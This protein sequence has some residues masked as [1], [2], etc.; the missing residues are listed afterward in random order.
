MDVPLPTSD[1]KSASTSYQVCLLRPPDFFQESSSKAIAGFCGIFSSRER[2]NWASPLLIVHLFFSKIKGERDSVRSAGHLLAQP[3][4]SFPFI[5]EHHHD[6]PITVLCKTLEVSESGYYARIRREPSQHCRE[7]ARLCADIQQIFLEHRQVYGS[8]RI[9]AVLKAR[10]IP[11]GRKRVVRLMQTLGLSAQVKK[12]RK[13]TTRSAPGRRFAPNQLN[14]EFAASLPNQKW[15]TDTKAVETAEG[16]LY[17]AVILDLFSRLVV[18]WAMAATEDEH[19]VELALRMALATRRPP[20]G[21][22]HHSDRGSEFTSDRYQA[23]LREAG[24]EVSMSRTGDCYDNAAMEA[25]FAT[26]TKECTDRVR[27][28]TRQEARSAIFEYLECF[29]NPV[30]LHSTLQY[31]SPVAFE[32]ATQSQMH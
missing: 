2:P 20:T 3:A 5:A 7:D 1:Q 27:F 12:R 16:W 15:V 21:L 6:Y 23:V 13:P 14:R 22:L 28:Q 18:G 10:G 25:F 17:L 30:R 8:P 9:H 11:C 24:I 31:V 32:Q 19:L 4:L 26:L 29:Y